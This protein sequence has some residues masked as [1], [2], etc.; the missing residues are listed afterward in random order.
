[1]ATAN[2]PDELG[3]YVTAHTTGSISHTDDVQIRLAEAIEDELIGK[4]LKRGILT[5][6]PSIKGKAYWQDA[7][8]I[9]YR[10]EESWTY[11]EYYKVNLDLSK[12]YEKDITEKA[13][14]T[15][16]VKPLRL[17]MKINSATYQKDNAS[18][19]GA[20]ATSEEID[21]TVIE[22][23]LTA[24]HTGT[25]VSIDWSHYSAKKHGFEISTIKRKKE[26]T[27]LV[28]NWNGTQLDKTFK[29]KSTVNILPDGDLKII[30]S[31]ALEDGSHTVK[32][33]FSNELLPDQNL[34]GLISINKKSKNLKADIIG[35]SI[36][37]YPSKAINGNFDLYLDKTIKKYDGTSLAN[38]Y[39]V[40][41]SFEPTSPGLLALGHGV[42]VP[43][44]KEVIF[45]FKAKNLKG[46]TVEIFKIYQDNVLQ[47]LQ[48]NQLDNNYRLDPVGRII[49]QEHINLSSINTENNST[50]YVRYALDLSAM[51]KLDQG[52]IYQVRI[53]YSMADIISYPCDEDISQVAAAQKNKGE[54]TSILKGD[55][56]RNYNYSERDNPCKSSYYT[57]RRFIARNVLASNMGVIAK[58]DP[59]FIATTTVTDLRTV[60]PSVGVTCEYYDFQQ[61]LIL[62]TKT[63][64][65]GM[66]KVTLPR[67]PSFLIT[68]QGAEFG[69]VSLKDN[70]A[71]STSE[72]DVAGSQKSDGIDGYIYGERG[73]WRPGDTL[74]VNFML[75]D[76]AGTLP[77]DHPVTFTVK[78]ARGKEKY[79]QI[80]SNHLGHIYHF[81][82]PTEK[83]AVTGNWRAEARIGE[84]VFQKTLKVETVK[85]NR[86]KV[87][88]KEDNLNLN[89]N[90]L[91][92][93]KS[94]WLHG[95]PAANLRAT[96]DLSLKSI[97]TSFPSYVDYTFDDMA[98]KFSPSPTQIFDGSLN[99]NGQKVIT[100]KHNKTWLPPGKLK[101]KIETKVFEKGGNFNT[102]TYTV[103]ADAYNS[104]VGIKIPTNRWGS[105]YIGKNDGQPIQIVLVDKEGKP[106]KNR[107]LSVGLYEARWNW[108]YERGYS[109][110]YRYNSSDHVGSVS[111]TNIATDDNGKAT[112]MPKENDHYI[113]MVRVCDEKT[114][115]CTGD[116]FYNGYYEDDYGDQSSKNRE[117]ATQLMFKADKK[118]YKTGEE[119]NLQIPSA[120]NS[121]IYLAIENGQEVLQSFW[122]EG[123]KDYTKISIP[124]TSK[125][126]SN[127]FIHAHLVQPHNN[128]KN[129]L[130]IRMY[131]ILPVSVIDEN[132]TLTPVIN[133]PDK[134]KPNENYEITVSETNGKSMYYTLAVVDEGLLSLTRFNTPS[135]WSKFYSKQALGVKTWDVYDFVLD[136]YGGAVDQYISIGGDGNIV[137]DNA[138]DINRFKSVVKHL[139]PFKL[140]A[141]QTVTHKLDMGNYVGAVRAMVVARNGDE[142]GNAEKSV[143]VKKPLMV[144]TTLPR[145]LGPGE[146]LSLAANVWALEDNIKNVN[147]SVEASDNI[148]FVSGQSSQLTFDQTGDKLSTFD[149]K[150]ANQTGQA[151][152][153]TNVKS[154]NNTA[155]EEVNIEI[156]NPQPYTT[157][158]ISKM[159]KPGDSWT[160]DY[161]AHGTPGTND[162]S[163]E[164]S[165]IPPVNFGKRLKYLMNYPYGCLEQTTSS[166][167]PQLYLDQLVD[168]SE[169]QIFK[170]KNNISAAI[171]RLK[172]FQ[173]GNGGFAYWIGGT[174]ANEWGT[175]YAGHFLLEA[176]DRGYSVPSDLIDYFVSYQTAS[177]NSTTN[178]GLIQ[179]YRLYTLTRA[180]EPNVGAMNRL[181]NN[182]NLDATTAHTL[183]A[184]YALIGQPKAAN[185]LL[186]K[187]DKEIKPYTET[188]YT[189]GSN[190]RDMALIALT[191]H[192]LGREDD[193]I[194]MISNISKYLNTNNWYS[195]Q[196][197]AFSLLALGTIYSMYPSDELKFSYTLSGNTKAGIIS[198]KSIYSREIMENNITNGTVSVTNESS[199]PQFV[200]II[201]GGQR[202]LDDQKPAVQKHIVMEVTYK[203][204]EGT[205]INPKDLKQGTDFIAE[206]RVNNPGT[207]TVK[208]E[209]V[210]LT[211]I[212]PSGWEIQNDRLNENVNTNGYIEYQNIRDDRVQTF[213][214]LN[215]KQSITIKTKLT[216]AYAGEF[217]MPPTIVEAMYDNEI[218][219]NTVGQWVTVGK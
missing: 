29:G 158:V 30:G 134:I 178:T 54:F 216:A 147:V 35:S 210:A 107:S 161:K 156:R 9:I 47:F 162:G 44:S 40:Q 94:D 128:G 17:T 19:K 31:E 51:T 97:S 46:A 112:F 8:T 23:M 203:D 124:T 83:D 16:H 111:K 126:N 6:S 102:D 81:P 43:H 159:I 135:P 42:I 174:T 53:G 64:A 191:Q 18:V 37:I 2:I 69:Y 201:L 153:I 27:N 3:Q 172:R 12:I 139:G 152:F 181:R 15:V 1:M 137:L 169:S 148:S 209:E 80:T 108:W 165:N 22:K 136:G 62:S 110:K 38:A 125:M 196:T 103:T 71:N 106:L 149:A 115:H 184:A 13:H 132:S 56:G 68:R 143:H 195:T 193:A 177:A 105:K 25:S 117:G 93:L 86:I 190:V 166:A 119:I 88:Y 180:G 34:K 74:F 33:N 73:V 198:E 75:E 142:Y 118:A 45:P 188:G 167:F 141:R 121:K 57:K 55:Y 176:K 84:H 21:D 87:D 67:K 92:S 48:Y 211:Q 208:I 157:E 206:V 76:K 160:T 122:V 20:I 82:I 189:Y 90:A 140:N 199:T 146:S 150:V 61:Q 99:Q 10:P 151:K 213:F 173:L 28:L 39:S 32:I 186:A 168:L 70:A 207:R 113:Y 65:K 79:K 120:P 11:D 171:K 219:A 215:N 212:F 14:F 116:M 133:M 72:F 96:V 123:K 155:M 85:P 202:P 200:K 131:G 127:I 179:A 185:E 129:D 50:S 183:A 49:H 95:S 100:I 130:P 7:Y 145:V 91:L 114:G 218:S 187:V 66:S 60:K 24:S 26:D 52:A 4:E 59:N 205:V 109:N 192:T 154:G 77:T 41:L 104:Y 58:V 182:K 204:M 36:L 163:L 170:T 217:Y 175:N 63:N 101:A 144:Q 89:D 164:I 5:L 194:N 138:Q 78:D 197:T 214:D 98:R